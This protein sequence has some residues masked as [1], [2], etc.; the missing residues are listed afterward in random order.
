M[1]DRI[2]L[3]DLTPVFVRSIGE[4]T[5]QEVDSFS[6]A[7]GVRFSCPKCYIEAGRLLVGVHSVLCWGPNAPQAMLPGPARWTFYG[8]GF[9]DLT[10]APSI[11]ITSGCMWHGFVQNGHAVL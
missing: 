10:L 4:T 7:E 8:T 9:D 6:E 2:P 3:R 1:T 5:M 11:Q